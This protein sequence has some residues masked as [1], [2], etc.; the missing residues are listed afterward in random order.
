MNP[1]IW[2]LRTQM[3]AGPAKSRARRTISIDRWSMSMVLTR[4]QL[5]D[6]RT[7]FHETLRHGAAAF[8]WVDPIDGS[9]ERE[10]RIVGEYSVEPLDA[11]AKW[12]V[13]FDVEFLPI[14]VA[15][16]TPGDPPDPPGGGHDFL[17]GGDPFAVLAE[18]AF[19]FLE[20]AIT[21]PLIAEAVAAPPD[22]NVV[23]FGNIGGGF[24]GTEAFENEGSLFESNPY[25]DIAPPGTVVQLE[26][27][28]IGG[29]VS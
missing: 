27:M 3:D 18:E 4:A 11:R 7:F 16:P 1:E 10:A 5:I 26:N 19:D 6:F 23:L 14:V 28:A 2:M 12:E 15:G 13:A 20:P 17:R 8:D 24:D 29:G 25:A 21:Q 22:L 9:T